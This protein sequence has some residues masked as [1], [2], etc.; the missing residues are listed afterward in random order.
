[1]SVVYSLKLPTVTEI[2]T[3]TQKMPVVTLT[4]SEKMPLRFHYEAECHV[5]SHTLQTGMRGFAHEILVNLFS[6]K[7]RNPPLQLVSIW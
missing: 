2:P 4:Y 1:M 7:V 6:P 3:V 5:H